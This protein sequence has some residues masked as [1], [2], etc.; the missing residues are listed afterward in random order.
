[1]KVN[2]EWNEWVNKRKKNDHSLKEWKDTPYNMNK[3]N[4][5]NE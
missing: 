5:K 1:M 2:Y 3:R 4:T